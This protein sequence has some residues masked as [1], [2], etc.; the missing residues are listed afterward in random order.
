MMA[1][2]WRAR[3]LAWGL[4]NL[5]LVVPIIA[6]A[7]L[8]ATVGC[9]GSEKR[10]EKG[11]AS[12]A[13]APASP[14]PAS[15]GASIPVHT[16]PP[17]DTVEAEPVT[18]DVTSVRQVLAAAGIIAAARADSTRQ[19]FMRAPGVVLALPGG[20]LQLYIYGDAVARGQDTDL[21]DTVRV[22]PPTSMVAW[23]QPATLIT[24]N[25]LAAILLT[26]DTALR[27]GV[28][29]ALTA[30]AGRTHGAGGR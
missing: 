29:R 8:F 6:A 16:G 1:N 23:R 12:G 9:R 26:G 17:H 21:L 15:S 28:R 27:R 25:N 13:D 3:S 2:S 19:N 20:D 22:A 14:P 24:D 7:G 5:R 30:H 11:V 10:E 18:W 4:P